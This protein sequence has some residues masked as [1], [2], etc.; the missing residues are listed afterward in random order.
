MEHA[1]IPYLREALIFLAAAGIAVPLL[2]RLRVN[3]IIG[4][5]LIGSVIG[6]YRL[7]LLAESVPSGRYF[8][9]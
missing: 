9:R 7:G 8:R 2:S 3:P 6:P 1:A 5:L 4:Y